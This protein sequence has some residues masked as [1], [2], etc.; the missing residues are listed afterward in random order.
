VRHNTVPVIFDLL[1]LW[2]GMQQAVVAAVLMNRRTTTAILCCGFHAVSIQPSRGQF[3]ALRLLAQ[4]RVTKL[5]RY[6]IR[7]RGRFLSG[8]LGL[9]RWR[10]GAVRIPPFPDGES[11][12]VCCCCCCCF[13]QVPAT[14]VDVPVPVSPTSRPPAPAPIQYFSTKS[15]ASNQFFLM[16]DI[17]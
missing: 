10:R 16:L 11:A 12:S 5:E 7:T 6:L 4:Q 8:G 1:S 14:P 15:C 2:Y 9:D 13:S 3:A 17:T